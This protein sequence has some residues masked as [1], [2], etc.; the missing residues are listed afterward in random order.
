[1]N[2]IFPPKIR[3]AIYIA[4]VMGSAVLVP[5]NA[6]GEVSNLVMSVWT[7]VSGAAAGLAALNVNGKA[8]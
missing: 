7:S 6:A 8:R 3:A 5:L 4:V 1:M 2:L